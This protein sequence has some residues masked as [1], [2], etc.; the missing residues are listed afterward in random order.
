MM[1]CPAKINLFLKVVG[2]RKDGY[3][4]LE[5][6][7]AFVDLF[8][9]LR[10][11]K[12]TQFSLQIS[13]EFGHLLDPKKNLLTE[14]LDFFFR[15]FGVEKNLKISLEK[16]IPIGA[17]LGGGSSN[18]AYFMMALNEIFA[19]GLDKK[20][21]QKISLNFGSD[22]AF[23]FEKKASLI[24]GRGE[25]IQAFPAFEPLSALLI[26][27]KINLSTKQVFAKLGNVF[28]NKIVD[29]KLLKSDALKLIRDLPN[30]LTKPAIELVPAIAEVLEK[31]KE[32]GAEVSKMSG[33]GSTCFGVF[34]DDFKLR[35]AQENLQKIF[36]NFLVKEVKILWQC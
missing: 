4:E 9:I 22:I 7:F 1:R 11:E 29:E 24:R 34:A 36:P 32:N 6:L 30:E 28:S 27:P 14:I 18:A 20:N 31:L 2:V 10:V 13:G 8:D 17:G 19:L 16:N 33:S 5:S 26:N 12:S 15:E 3:R 21:L 23:F 25:E 35:K